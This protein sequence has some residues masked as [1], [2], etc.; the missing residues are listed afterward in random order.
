MSQ[1]EEDAEFLPTL[2]GVHAA[3]LHPDCLPTPT[4]AK[5][6]LYFQ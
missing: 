5:I 1:V 2:R 6:D 3:P 4:Q